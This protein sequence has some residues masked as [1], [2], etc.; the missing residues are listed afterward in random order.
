MARAWLTQTC[1]LVTAPVPDSLLEAVTVEERVMGSEMD[2]LSNQEVYVHGEARWPC[3]L[4]LAHG[5]VALPREAVTRERLEALGYL[6]TDLRANI[7]APCPEACEYGA[8]VTLRPRQHRAYEVCRHRSGTVVLGTGVG[9]TVVLLKAALDNGDRTLVI[10]DNGALSHQWMGALCHDPKLFRVPEH[11]VGDC[12]GPAHRWHWHDRIVAVTTFQSLTLQLKQ[13]AVP[14]EFFSAFSLVCWDEAHVAM[15]PTRLPVLSL[16]PGRRITLTATPEIR[17]REKAMYL[18]AGPV[19][20]EDRAPELV[21]NVRVR[22]LPMAQASRAPANGRSV[23]SYQ[24]LLGLVMGRGK[25]GWGRDQAYIHSVAETVGELRAQRRQIMVLSPRTAFSDA[26]AGAVGRANVIDQSVAFADRKGMLNSSDVV[27]VTDKI[28]EK[29]LDRADLDA[30][31]LA[32]PVG[33]E[34][35]NRLRQAC[36][37]ILRTHA[38]KTRTPEVI[39]FY[40][41]CA[42]GRELADANALI[43]ANLGFKVLEAPRT[44]TSVAFAADGQRKHTGSPPPIA[45]VPAVTHVVHRHPP[46]PRPRTP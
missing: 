22:A 6:V 20:V 34:A 37:R 26:L 21:P 42:Y 3:M 4:P 33:K 43:C 40:P 14:P 36:G 10:V 11:L 44:A 9:K 5:L 15:S 39:I 28:G 30:L 16:F 1:I 31:V 46:T 2:V 13:H 25:G 12:T 7:P 32:F 8:R 18:H 19:L 29:G 24:R 27:I 35:E 38:V 17:G 45:K 41:D 23:G